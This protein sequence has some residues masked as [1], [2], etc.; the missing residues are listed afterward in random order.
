MKFKRNILSSILLLFS[1][2]VSVSSSIIGIE[3]EDAASV[4][5][6]IADISED[7]ILMEYN[8]IKTFTPAS[9][10]KAVTTASAISVLGT[11]YRFKTDVYITGENIENTLYGNIQLEGFGDPTL[12]SMHFPDNKGFVDSIVSR[13]K[14]L[15]ITRIKGSVVAGQSCVK[16][17]GIIS[18]WEIE[19][20]AWAY[21]AGYYGL[22]Y[23]DNT[24]KLSI[25][26][27]ATVPHI[28]GLTILDNTMAGKNSPILQRGIDSY[29]LEVSGTVPDKKEISVS[30]SMPD[31]SR[32]LLD[33]I[34]CKLSENGIVVENENVFSKDTVLLFTHKSPPLFEI[35]RS[36]MYRS[37]N[38][39][40]EGVLRAISIG[41][42]R[43]DAIDAEIAMWERQNID[44]SCVSIY[45]GSG[46]SRCNRI[47][48]KFMGN[49]LSW[50]AKS[51]MA[52]DYVALFPKAGNDGTLRRFLA[53]SRLTGEVAL[54]TG[55]MNGVQCYA[56]YKLDP[57][58]KPTHVIVIMVNNF[59]CKRKELINGI[60][61]LLLK[62]F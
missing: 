30:C 46:L 10:L 28:A 57:A 43:T 35:M 49:V 36:L 18:K 21:G 48:P 58:G 61:R 14:A 56:G 37:D 1:C 60:E 38:L 13:I 53:N 41:D 29:V 32:V 33:S 7:N 52:N 59:F 50:M 9:I 27:L 39:M 62:I 22:N 54:K 42:T 2:S 44:C 8:G 45:D 6:Y 31:P 47:S 5:V 23:M 20:V 19:D 12:E 3:N 4:G 16:D 51:D 34:Y 17:Q 25:P 26:S 55:S 40:A 24:F 15:G 11:E